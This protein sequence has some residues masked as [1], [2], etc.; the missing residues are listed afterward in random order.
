MI[1]V[2]HHHHHR[3]SSSS[4]PSS[5]RT[6]VSIKSL[7]AEAPA[8][9]YLSV[10]KQRRPQSKILAAH[11]LSIAT[12]PYRHLS[13]TSASKTAA[14]AFRDPSSSSGYASLDRHQPIASI[15][16]SRRRFEPLKKKP[17]SPSK[18]SPLSTYTLF[19]FER[20]K[21]SFSPGR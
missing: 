11:H 16:P 3:A 4:S 9:L 19:L 20:R 7:Q 2:D 15:L 10:S 17:P 6:S 5:L 1:G 12:S 14:D 21:A 18:S 13:I 8:S